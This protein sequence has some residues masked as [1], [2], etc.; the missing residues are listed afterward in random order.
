LLK[1]SLYQPKV[2]Y[3]KFFATKSIKNSTKYSNDE[4]SIEQDADIIISLYRDDY[5]NQLS[6]PNST[7]IVELNVLKNRN[8]QTGKVEASFQKEYGLFLNL[9]KHSDVANSTLKNDR[10]PC[11]SRTTCPRHE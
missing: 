2:I 6:N 5:Y 3:R 1:Y 8:G 11:V 10:K 7:S 4:K 9:M